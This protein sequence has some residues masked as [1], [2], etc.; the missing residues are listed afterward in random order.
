MGALSTRAAIAF[1]I[2]AR[3]LALIAQFASTMV[4]AR[5]LTPEEI[6]VYSAG[7]TLIALAHLFRDFGLNQYLI[8]EQRLDDDK[9][10]TAFTLTILISWGLGAL[11]LFLAQPAAEFFRQPGIASLVQ[12]LAINFFIIPFGSVTL[13]LLRKQL[14]FQI[15]S[16]IGIVATLLGIAVAITTAFQGASY[17]CLA[18]GAI[19][20]TGT[21]VLLSL[22]FRPTG[23]KLGLGLGLGL[24]E[25]SHILKFGSLV[26]AGNIIKHFS[27]NATDAIIARSLGMNALG[28]YSRA[29][30]T[31]SLFD[32][33]YTKSVNPI[34]LPLFSRS[35]GQLESVRSGYIKAVDYTAIFAWPFFGF[36]YF[37]TDE[38][39]LL[40][41]GTQW[42]EAVPLV[43]TLC[44]AGI[45]LP[46]SLLSDNLFIAM[47][48]PDITLKIR[49]AAS[50]LL[51]SLV[52]LLV[53]RGLGAVALCLVAFHGMR[54]AL[55]LLYAKSTLQL[56]VSFLLQSTLR[57]LPC[58]LLALAPA[59]LLRNALLQGSSA[60]LIPMLV[61]ALAT[62]LGWLAG[63]YLS[64]H[65][66]IEELSPA[67]HKL[68]RGRFARHNR[69]QTPK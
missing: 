48:R 34:V 19:T 64:R 33:L 30:G 68:T 58:V 35:R 67:L 57:A 63:L 7:F 46:P 27:L 29:Y 28:Y 13:A 24:K 23:L 36:L 62:F 15:T 12:L 47:G 44:L 66:F 60:L 6:G 69:E 40:L 43:K 59:L 45:L 56:D 20:E 31:F 22:F 53:D 11:V 50:A 18:Y 65:P 10:A 4:L 37:F 21:T 14:K 42:G 55:T 3:Y 41:Y 54:T 32:H 26:G 1:S 16:S 51:V 61:I 49:I 2:G 52:A 39:I 9:V 25:G 17:Y 8:Q 5:L 38:V